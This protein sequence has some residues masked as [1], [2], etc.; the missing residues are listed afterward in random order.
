MALVNR[1]MNHQSVKLVCRG[2]WIALLILGLLARANSAE[3][4][5]TITGEKPGAGPVRVALYHDSRSFRHEDQAVAVLSATA[6]SGAAKV[7]FQGLPA[8]R[9]AV[10]AYHDENNNKKLDMTMGMFPR[11]GW[12]LS[13]DP[14]V[15]GPPEFRQ[16]AFDVG[17][18]QT[19]ITVPLHY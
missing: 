15:L 16:S 1:C 10:I 9:Y 8:G 14:H 19:S 2:S 12:G 18:S 6:E 7:V 3:L 11:E 17:E 4:D 5:V 13:N